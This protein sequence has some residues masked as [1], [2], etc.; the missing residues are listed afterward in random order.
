MSHT[1]AR[2]SRFRRLNWW[3]WLGTAALVTVGLARADAAPIGAAMAFTTAQALH[4]RH[5]RGTLLAPPVQTRIAYVLLLAL[6]CLTPLGFIHWLQLAG[7]TVSLTFDYCPLAR[8]LSLMPWNRTEP[9]S[10]HLVWRTFASPP[11][12]GSVFAPKRATA[13]GS[14][15]AIVEI[16][17]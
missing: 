5:Q 17:P 3:Y 7:T 11:V 10:P 9:L 4:F 15:T 1:H 8:T 2:P 13:R 16:S 6:G 14:A 12:L